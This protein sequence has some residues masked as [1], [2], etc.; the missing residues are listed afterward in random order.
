MTGLGATADFGVVRGRGSHPG[1][2][3]QTETPATKGSF[4]AALA[5]RALARRGFRP[6]P[7]S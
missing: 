1:K 5:Q 7:W 6:L 3:S 4:G 2:G